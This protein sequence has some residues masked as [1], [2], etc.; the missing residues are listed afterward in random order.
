[1]PIAATEVPFCAISV[2]TD[3]ICPSINHENGI[4]QHDHHMRSLLFKLASFFA[5][6]IA[7]KHDER[8][9]ADY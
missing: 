7:T 4:R 3:P 1:M 2:Y 8:M 6:L 5:S 9:Y